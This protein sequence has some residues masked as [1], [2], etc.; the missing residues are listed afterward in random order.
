MQ[1]WHA[2][3]VVLKEIVEHHI[4]DEENTLLDLAK[5]A[6]TDDQESSML[7]RFKK[8]KRK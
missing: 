6:L 2:K 8:K 5:D 7:C 4:K 1:D 3:L